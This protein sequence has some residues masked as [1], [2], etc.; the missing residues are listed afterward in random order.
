[1]ATKKAE[2]GVAVLSTTSSV[3]SVLSVLDEKLN[4]LKKVVD[5]PYKTTG[6]LDKFGDIKQETKMEN[7]IRAF[8]MVKSMEKAYSDAAIDLGEESVPAFSISGGSVE[9]WKQDIK[10]RIAI[11]KHKETYDKLN[12]YKE[13]MKQFLSAE[14]RRGILMHEMESFIS[15]L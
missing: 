11:I 6:N 4:S 15:K 9:D 12:K 10:L 2:T 1:M 13:E 3:P 8:S 14:D 5:T 7:L